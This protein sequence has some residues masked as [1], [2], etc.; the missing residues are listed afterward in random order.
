VMKR[1]RTLLFLAA[2]LLAG[3]VGSLPADAATYFVRTTGNDT[4]GDGST[5]NPWLTVSK[6][7]ATVAIGGGDVVNIGTGTYAENTSGATFFNI[8][9]L[10]TAET[11]FQS[12]TGNAADVTITGSSSASFNTLTNAANSNYHFK[13]VTFGAWATTTTSAIRVT[14]ATTSIKFTGCVFAAPSSNAATRYGLQLQPSGVTTVAGLVCTNCTFTGGS[15][16]NAQSLAVDPVAG[17]ITAPQFLN[18]TCTGPLPVNVTA[19]TANAALS[20]VVFNGGSVSGTAGYG[21]K[22][23]QDADT[24]IGTLGVT[25]S[26]MTLSTAAGTGHALL[27]GKGANGCVARCNQV[28]GADF[29]M[30]VKGSNLTAYGNVFRG[31]LVSAVNNAGIYCKG[32]SGATLIGNTLYCAQGTRGVLRVL[33]GDSANPSASITFKGNRVIADGA[34]VM[35]LEWGGA[36]D[37]SGGSVSDYNLYDVR[38]AGATYGNVRSATG[39]TTLAAVRS[40]WSGYGA[41]TNDAN[42]QDVSA[43]ALVEY[44]AAATGGFFYTLF[45]DSRGWYWNGAAFEAPANAN[46]PTYARLMFEDPPG[47]FRYTHH[48]PPFI[49]APGRYRAAVFGL[50]TSPAGYAPAVGDPEKQFQ[51][52]DW[53]GTHPTNLVEAAGA[54]TGD[55][56]VNHNTGGADNLAYKTAAGVGIDNAVVRAYLKA[57]YDAGKFTLRAQATTDVNGRWVAPMYLNAGNTYVFI[58]EKPGVFGPTKKE[59]AF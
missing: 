18:C 40:A 42:S 14:Q 59:Q 37:D 19:L 25:V 30:V 32:A 31:G 24:P 39:I 10:F 33:A 1:H 43:A 57:D 11:V 3:V 21:L 35:A 41:G 9:R 50:A 51:F 54:G 16:A 2:A 26:N 46:R 34:T 49:T 12:E 45:T 20:G 44:N 8:N 4:T 48:F 17:A 38:A 58:F 15:N 36:T 28:S 56:P 29:G 47:S 55:T 6:A 23:G 27:I 5:G 13:N 7:Q 53:Q 52:I 22:I